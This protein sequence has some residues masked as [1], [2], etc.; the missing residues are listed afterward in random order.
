MGK[1]EP[2]PPP[3]EGAVKPPPPPGPAGQRSYV[4]EAACRSALTFIH[5]RFKGNDAA[6]IKI[7]LTDALRR[8][9]A[10]I[11]DFETSGEEQ[12]RRITEEDRG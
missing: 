8:A 10:Y 2:N 3:P 7:Q 6:L 1:K 12:L 5:Y 11:P 4:L 9:G